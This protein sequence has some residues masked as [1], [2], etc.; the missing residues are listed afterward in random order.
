V[1]NAGGAGPALPLFFS[2]N[3][4]FYK[5]YKFPVPGNTFC[6]ARIPVPIPI[7][8]LTLITGAL[9]FCLALTTLVL[10]GIL[11]DLSKK[12]EL[13]EPLPARAVVIVIIYAI[14]CLLISP[15]FLPL[16]KYF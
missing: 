4:I 6:M 2:W 9:L 5:T 3:G 11:G 12:Y 1:K 8:S 16:L 13:L 14:I 15:Y 7:T 10:N